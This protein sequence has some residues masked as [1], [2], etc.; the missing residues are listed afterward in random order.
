MA[1]FRMRRRRRRG[2]TPGIV[3]LLIVVAG[4]WWLYPVG[5]LGIEQKPKQHSQNLPL[6][7]TDRPEDTQGFP[8]RPNIPEKGETKTPQAKP[9]A[10]EPVTLARART[11]I[12]AGKQALQ[13]N[14]PIAARTYFS[15]A[16]TA[17]LP[18]E[19]VKLLRA[20]LSRIGQLSIFSARVFPNDPFVSRYVI[21]AGDT[22]G[23]IAKA[24]RVSPELIA[25]I[26]NISDPNRIRE[27]QSIKMI[28][29]PFHIEVDCGSFT[30][31]VYLGSTFV[32][33]FP[34]GLG[35][36]NSTPR[37][38]WRVTTKLLNP[39]YYPPRGGQIVASDDPEN[40]L[41][42]RWI[43]LKGISGEATGQLRYGIHGT[44]EPE[45]IGKNVSLGCIRMHNEDVES[46]YSYLIE[47][48]STVTVID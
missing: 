34:V 24:H 23:K 38:Q 29:G 2:L 10:D 44:N 8:S 6:L 22:L 27:G 26:N 32:K 12:D 15:E 17:D 45:S 28:Q 20:E 7:I 47:K 30:M 36:D 16:L 25:K 13:K 46:L 21:H 42:E 14:D 40:P 43:G 39:T 9:S 48:Y 3:S 18:E 33:Q 5:E 31:G 11:L 1:K 4:V 35:L 37:G 41:G 19:D